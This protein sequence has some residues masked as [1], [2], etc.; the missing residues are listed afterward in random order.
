METVIFPNQYEYDLAGNITK[1]TYPSGKEVRYAFTTANRPASVKNELDRNYLT[2]I[3]YTPQGGMKALKFGNNLDEAITY[4]IRWQPERLEIANR[5]SLVYD[6][7]TGG[8]N[9]NVYGISDTITGTVYTYTYDEVNRIKTAQVTGQPSQTYYYDRWGNMR[10]NNPDVTSWIT[11]G[12]N[13]LSAY[14]YDAAGNQQTDATPNTYKYDGENRVVKLNEGTV[15]EYKYDAQGRRVLKITPASRRF[16]IYDQSGRMISEYEAPASGP[17]AAAPELISAGYGQTTYVHRDHLGSVRVLTTQD[18][19]VAER[20]DF[21]PFGEEITT[22]ANNQLKFTGKL[23][24]G[25]SG[26]DYFG[27]RYCTSTLG[28][29]MSV[30]PLRISP[31][32]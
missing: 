29:F 30:D 5:M 6:Y 31:A 12:T 4:N 15:A 23:R 9:G 24:D 14:V 26:L 2:N 19:S 7:T 20:R 25:E 21:L 17:L 27:A 11:P 28:R 16:F 22:T 10:K 13:R 18:T 8:N 3:T 32:I 1:I